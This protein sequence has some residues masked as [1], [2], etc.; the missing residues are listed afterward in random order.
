MIPLSH[1]LSPT[2]QQ[3]I[4]YV[5]K[6]HF[7][8]HQSGYDCSN[9]DFAGATI[10]NKKIFLVCVQNIMN[11]TQSKKIIEETVI[12]EA[13]HVAQYCG[14]RN[15]LG[16]PKNKMHLS[17]FK[18][19]DVQKSISLTQDPSTKNAEYEAYWLE[20]KPEQVLYYLKKFCF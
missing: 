8:V 5:S 13:V 11:A 2:G 20:D 18:L 17:A 10:H 14:G 7:K 1:Y 12:H 4:E 6:A 3:I 15:T 16:I 9:K 19:Y